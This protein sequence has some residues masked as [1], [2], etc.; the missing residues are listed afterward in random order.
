[1]SAD[2]VAR[3]DP[4]ELC[5]C[6]IGQVSSR[7]GAPL[8]VDAHAIS[9]RKGGTVQRRSLRDALEA[10]GFQRLVNEGKIGN[11]E[12][13]Q[14]LIHTAVDASLD[15]M[16]KLS[17]HRVDELAPYVRRESRRLR[18]WMTRRRELLESRMEKYGDRHPKARQYKKNLEEMEDYLR[19]RQENWLEAQFTPAKE[20]STQ[21]VLV[22]EGVK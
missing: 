18:T 10:A 16:R 8:V 9:V 14:M 4:G 6:F 19:D 22:I 21:L 15:H 17:D 12:A 7:A 2:H 20:P 1:M 3:L 11:I 13:A 5:F